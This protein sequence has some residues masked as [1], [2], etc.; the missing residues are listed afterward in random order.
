MSITPLMSGGI[1]DRDTDG[2]L[3]TASS[4]S[5]Q[6]SGVIR[7]IR[8][9]VGV[10]IARLTDAV[11]GICY[12]PS[13]SSPISIGGTITSSASKTYCESKLI[14]RLGDTVTSNCGHTG[15]IS[16][17]S[18]TV[19]AENKRVA[20]KGDSFSGTYVGTI[21]GSASKTFAS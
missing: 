5:A 17:A 2:T 16:S 1:I 12:H 7:S 14:S 6:T 3:I 9:G 19:Y 11:F 4:L 13:H 8:Q 18:S 20:R 15:T 10:L 21:T